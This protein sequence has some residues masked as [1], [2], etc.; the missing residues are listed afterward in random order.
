MIIPQSWL[1]ENVFEKIFDNNTIWFG[2]RKF[3]TTPNS[4]CEAIQNTF[5]CDNNLIKNTFFSEK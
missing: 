1:G 3:T 2:T 4:A 5:F